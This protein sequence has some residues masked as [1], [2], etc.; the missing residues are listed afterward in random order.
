MQKKLLVTYCL[1]YML[2][3]FFLHLRLSKVIQGY[4][5]F[6]KKTGYL[7]LFKM[8]VRVSNNYAICINCC[9]ENLVGGAAPLP[10]VPAPLGLLRPTGAIRRS[11]ADAWSYLR[12]IFPSHRREIIGQ[13]RPCAR[14][15][16]TISLMHII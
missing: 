15:G 5:F 14:T 13:R 8:P 4:L 16:L 3:R 10:P 2:V 7:R 12:P 1:N 6:L 11:H 9:K